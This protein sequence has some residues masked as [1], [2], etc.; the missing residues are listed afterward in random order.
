MKNSYALKI[1]YDKKQ[2]FCQKKDIKKEENGKKRS[3][4]SIFF[5]VLS[6]FTTNPVKLMDLAK[7]KWN[8]AEEIRK[9]FSRA[10]LL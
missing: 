7:F 5:I 6:R 4:V 3:K 9:L 10:K 1:L 2:R 8:C